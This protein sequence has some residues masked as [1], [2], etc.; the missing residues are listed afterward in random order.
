VPGFK[1]KTFKGIAPIVPPY[2]LSEDFA[3]S[4]TD[5]KL[6]SG[7]LVG[8]ADIVLDDTPSK[9]GT[10]QSIYKYRAEGEAD[11]WFH[12]NEVVDVVKSPVID[13][14]KTKLYFS[15][16]TNEAPKITDTDLARTGASTDYPAV[17]YVLGVPQPTQTPVISSTG[18]A[19]SSNTLDA[20]DRYYV[21][22]YVDFTGGESAP[23]TVSPKFTIFPGQTATVAVTADAVTNTDLDFIRIYVTN[24]GTLG[25]DFQFCGEVAFSTQVFSDTG[26]RAEI[27]VTKTWAVPDPDMIGIT[28]MPNGILAGFRGNTLMFSEPYAPYAWPIEYRIS[29]EYEIVGLKASGD[30]LVV[31]TEG[32]PYIVTGPTSAAMSFSK[33][34]MEQ[35]CVS[36]RS[37]V[38]V[39]DG[40]IYASPDG[41]VF[42]GASGLQLLTEDLISREQW[43][44]NYS[45]STIHAHQHDNL[46]Y[47]FYGGTAGFIFDPAAK[48]LVGL[49]TYATGGFND[50]IDDTL[51]L[52]IADKIYKWDAGS[53]LTSYTWKSKTFR[54]DSP[55]NFG[56]ARV[57]AASY[58]VTFKLYA[59]GVL[60]HTQSVASD[61]GFR[62][63]SGFVSYDF[64]VELSGSNK[65]E[66]VYIADTPSELRN[67]Q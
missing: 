12:W 66:A 60:K 44:A 3:V 7:E 8:F 33:L 56:A 29:L 34:D 1:I 22:T 5:C 51:Y 18:T 63:P 24:T 46:Y 32:A 43:Q 28:A 39:L 30:K 55:V 58:P 6:T 59:D 41:L 64:E 23:S 17:D 16:E 67:L 9:T 62:L 38:S 50:L 10:L 26:T 20:E 19:T 48:H 2:K 14:S 37:M 53:S 36:K 52:I 49:T 4:A 11:L 54:A 57:K 47:G 25:S 35:A 61:L 15:G 45:P 40:V 27:L 65:I 42:I 13:D 31:G 21:Y